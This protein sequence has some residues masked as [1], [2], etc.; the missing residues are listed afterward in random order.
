MALV[1]VTAAFHLTRSHAE[2]GSAPIRRQ[3]LRL[4]VDTQHDGSLGRDHVGAD[5]VANLGDEVRM[6]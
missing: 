3:D 2:R 1:V 5:D 4:F 6:V